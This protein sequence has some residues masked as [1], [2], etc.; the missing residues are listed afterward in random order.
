M[1]DQLSA[2]FLTSFTSL[3]LLLTL[4]IRHIHR[5]QGVSA[6][7]QT[8]ALFLLFTA[9][10][11]LSGVLSIITPVHPTKLLWE[12]VQQTFSLLMPV[13]WLQFV[14][15]YARVSALPAV[16]RH[17]LRLE[18]LLMAALLWT[19]PQHH[20]FFVDWA[21]LPVGF[22]TVLCPDHGPASLIHAAFASGLFLVSLGLLGFAARRHPDRS[23]R[24]VAL[25]ALATSV[26]WLLTVAELPPGT[27][28]EI[29]GLVAATALLAGS[30]LALHIYYSRLLAVIP[31][32]RKAVIEQLNDGIIILNKAGAIA[33][34]NPAAARILNRPCDALIGAQPTQAFAA[35]PELLA[36]Y[37]SPQ[38]R[39]APIHVQDAE[40]QRT[41]EMQS[42]PLVNDR[43]MHIGQMIVLHD[44]SE[45]L[46][47]EETLQ[48]AHRMSEIAN[49]TKSEFLANM[50][51]EL[52]T[53]LNSIIGYTDLI[54]MGI[55]GK[56]NTM[57]RTRLEQVAK[58]AKHLARLLGDIIDIARIE[59]HDFHLHLEVIDPAP[60]LV[61]VIASARTEAHEKGLALH[62]YIP[63][64]L[65]SVEV[66]VRRMRQIIE[67][68]LSNAIKFT[69]E[70]YLI[71]HA[72]VV[73]APLA[74][75]FPV[76]LAEDTRNW[77]IIAVQD[78]GIGIPP[79]HHAVIFE[80]FRQIDG[81][82]TRRYE[83]TGLG[84]AV[85]SRFTRLMHGQMWVESTPDQG[86]SFYVVLPTVAA[87]CEETPA[88][89]QPR[90]IQHH[91]SN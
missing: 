44:I 51:H 66:D 82:S 3:A 23:W 62:A 28:G 42:K 2:I 25:L 34:A 53:P 4:I 63:P 39:P 32:A 27:Q 45:H 35:H 80:E 48:E 55:Y 30:D 72:G 68:L 49:R 77:L 8:F 59:A 29:A 5:R 13:L 15:R 85:A 56:L 88:L 16:G 69:S 9:A 64:S 19:S 1:T 50:S 75:Q 84:L 90:V 91:D 17:I 31:A 33:D 60:L 71:I 22:F 73:D 43:G 38:T 61:E 20:L 36:S 41:Y 70:G 46:K 14:L 78:T 6:T 57:Q 65:P 7:W 81:S 87:T 12:L 67:H 86:T 21:A 24:Q 74:R 47:V 58:N 10:W 11:I 40:D 54:L 26:P 89:H 37:A 76:Q 79:E 52:R 18:P 83:G